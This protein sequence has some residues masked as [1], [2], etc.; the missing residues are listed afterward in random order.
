LKKLFKI[1]F[2]LL[3]VNQLHAQY[4]SPYVK[5]YGLWCIGFGCETNNTNDAEL[6]LARNNKGLGAK[7]WLQNRY[8]SQDSHWVD[9]KFKLDSVLNTIEN[10]RIRAYSR[11]RYATDLIFTTSDTVGNLRDRFLIY[12]YGDL[13][14]HKYPNTRT[15]TTT[16]INFLY[17]DANGVIQS[18]PLTDLDTITTIPGGGDDCLACCDSLFYFPNDTAAL[19]QGWVDSSEYY[20]LSTDNTYGWSWGVIK[21]QMVDSVAHWEISSIMDHGVDGY[22]LGTDYRVGFKGKG[23]AECKLKF[24]T[25]YMN[26]YDSDFDAY[27]A[28][29]DSGGYYRLSLSNVYGN[30]EN[31]IKKLNEY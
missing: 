29:V 26:Q 31:F 28:G 11:S 20:L 15:D 12:S 16:A 22:V 19:L 5:H 18:R 10:A 7:L 3:C 4:Y 23:F 21:Q 27:T 1:L 9:V 13:R 8:R 17:T 30:P 2:I 6:T 24:P 25:Q 14:A